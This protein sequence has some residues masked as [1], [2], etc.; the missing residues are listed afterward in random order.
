VGRKFLDWLSDYQFLKDSSLW[1]RWQRWYSY[2]R[3]FVF[4]ML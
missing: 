4:E 3:I 1:R 2:E